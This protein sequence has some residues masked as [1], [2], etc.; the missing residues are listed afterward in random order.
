MLNEMIFLAPSPFF[1]G[2]AFGN[3]LA[4]WE[5]MGVF[6][7]MLPFL[8]IFALIYGILSKMNLFGDKENKSINAI[9]SLSVALMALQFELV[10]LFFSDVLPRLGVALAAVL[11][12][13]IL[14]GLFGNPENKGFMNTMMWGSFAIAIIIILQSLDV[15]GPGV[16]NADYILKFIPPRLIHIFQSQAIS[17][18]IR[19]LRG[20]ND[21][22]IA[23]DIT[24]F[25][26][27]I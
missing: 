16:R 5:Q 10:T 11:V 4:Q 20:P 18:W 24:F 17:K 6:S 21:N 13:L 25:E 22:G 14:I 27:I 19:H 8:L 15:F 9:I 3:L 7:Y 2:G 1:G 12:I 26:G 23:F